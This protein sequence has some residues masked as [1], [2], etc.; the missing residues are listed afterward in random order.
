MTDPTLPNLSRLR[1][2]IGDLTRLVERR[3]ANSWP[4]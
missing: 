1:G 4:G 2:F 3:D